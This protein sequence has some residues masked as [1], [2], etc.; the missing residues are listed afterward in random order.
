MN[1]AIADLE[2]EN[3]RLSEL[4]QTDWLTGLYNRCTMEEK[5]NQCLITQ[6]G[7]ALFVLDGDHLKQ[8]NDRFGHTAGDCLL[9][10]MAKV[11]RF[12]VAS[13]GLLGRI[14]GDEFVIYLPNVPTMEAALEQSHRFVDRIGQIHLETAGKLKVAITIGTSLYKA[15]DDYKRLFD[16]ADQR[17]ITAK[18]QRKEGADGMEHPGLSKSTAGG[19]A[20]DMALISDELTEQQLI[21]G[22]FCQD[23]DMFKV[24]FRF[25]ARRL[26]RTKGN[27]YLILLTLTD[28]NGDFPSLAEREA[29]MSALSQIIQSSL[30]L[31]DVF[32]QYSS[33]QFLLMV[34]DA[35]EAEANMIATRIHDSFFK[36]A[37]SN[38]HHLLLHHCYPM[39]P[40]PESLPKQD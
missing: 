21:P 14:G 12:M 26:K 10:E 19:I 22:A 3:A 40:T 24:I 37:S 28:K 20:I 2:Q 31:G 13:Q 1:Q 35:A 34:P 38:P 30:R 36:D 9:Q 18:R 17:L 29:Q 5:I 25:M 6:P 39:L 11:L 8:I 33:C 23:Y 4:A 16:R 27:S 32:T 7:G 15:G